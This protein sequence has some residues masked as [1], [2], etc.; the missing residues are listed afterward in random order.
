MGQSPELLVRILGQVPWESDGD[1]NSKHPTWSHVSIILLKT[2][3]GQIQYIFGACIFWVLWLARSYHMQFTRLF[4][5]N[6]L[7][8]GIL[9]HFLVQWFV[10]RTFM[11]EGFRRWIFQKIH[12]GIAR[13]TRWSIMCCLGILR[14]KCLRIFQPILWDPV[15]F[16]GIHS[17]LRSQAISQLKRNACVLYQWLACCKGLEETWFSWLVEVCYSWMIKTLRL[18]GDAD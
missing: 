4:S 14:S 6:S 12:S 18:P 9:K 10:F 11:T 7:G 2:W 16:L 13:H 15:S 5:P 1:A 8:T 3:Q 17:R